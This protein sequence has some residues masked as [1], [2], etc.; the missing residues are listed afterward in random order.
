MA[1]EICRGS[2]QGAAFFSRAQF[3]PGDAFR[4][5]R[6]PRMW[7]RHRN[8]SQRDGALCELNAVHFFTRQREE[9]RSAGYFA[10]VARDRVDA[11]VRRPAHADAINPLQYFTQIHIALRAILFVP[12]SAAFFTRFWPGFHRESQF[13]LPCE[14]AGTSSPARP[15]LTV[16]RLPRRTRAPL[17]GDCSTATPL[18]I[19]PGTSPS[20]EHVSETARTVCPAR[21]GTITPF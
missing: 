20:R 5:I 15:N 3:D 10:A 21:F 13:P 8:R 16:T 14:D 2:R 17:S 1:V 11:R 19:N 6:R 4:D 18:P 12:V 9:K 7:T